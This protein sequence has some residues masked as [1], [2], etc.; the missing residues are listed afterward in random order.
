MRRLLLGVSFALIASQACVVPD[1]TL[2]G[3]KCDADGQC[4]DGFVCQGGVCLAQG[5]LGTAC[6]A[7][8]DCAAQALV[9]THGACAEPCVAPACVCEP[10]DT[11]ACGSNEG[12][13]VPGTQVCGD[14]HQWGACSGGVVSI[15]ET[16][17]GEDDDC[18]GIADD[19]PDMAC[20]QGADAGACTT[21]CGTAGHEACNASC[22][23]YTCVTP[24]EVCNGQDDDC[25]GAVD[26]GPSFVCVQGADAGSC[27]TTCGTTGHQACNM[28]CTGL[29]ACVPPAEVC[30]GRDDDC[31][32]AIDNGL[33]GNVNTVAGPAAFG[34]VSLALGPGSGLAVYTR[35]GP[36]HARIELQRLDGALMPTGG[37]VDHDTGAEQ[38]S[39]IAA[40]LGADAGFVAVWV[41]GGVVYALQVG[42]DGSIEPVHQISAGLATVTHVSVAASSAGVAYAWDE[43]ASDGGRT[44][45]F[46]LLPSTDGGAHL[47]NV[48]SSASASSALPALAASSDGSTYGLA[49]V[50]GGATH[51]GVF[52]AAGQ[53]VLDLSPT[54][55]A[56]GTSA[57]S[58]AFANGGYWVA[59][60]SGDRMACIRGNLDGGLSTV[61]VDDPAG[62]V[63]GSPALV[64]DQGE[65]AFLGWVHQDASGGLQMRMQH[66]SA[67][68]GVR[69]FQTTAASVGPALAFDGADFAVSWIGA[70][71]GGG[72][73]LEVQSVCF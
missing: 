46:V 8:S 52:S 45:I 21:A 33:T 56:A 72:A 68:G 57:P 48:T 49:Y 51:A 34:A 66:L 41:E 1:V 62:G 6:V 28:F 42:P 58:I 31:D 7:D 47:V 20:V 4:L 64:S 55:G 2:A 67:D 60:A 11:Q 19:G 40:A 3:K 61:P 14:D 24:P 17:N 70:D 30:N 53:R 59:G 16:C 36:G 12:E 54:W 13:C 44:D 18:D 50:Q 32:S 69:T 43:G 35:G 9:C 29:T 26:D 27:Q 65:L 37:P 38:T 5:T 15:T 71:A 10:G 23:G 39:P 63:S 73:V 22:S 25:N